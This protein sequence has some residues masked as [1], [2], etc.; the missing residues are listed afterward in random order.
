VGPCLG[1]RSEEDDEEAEDE[2]EDE[3][4]VEEEEEMGRRWKRRRAGGGGGGGGGGGSRGGGDDGFPYTFRVSHTMVR[5]PVRIQRGTNQ[6]TLVGPEVGTEVGAEVGAEVGP[7]VGPEVGLTVGPEVGLTV[8]PEVGL[9]VGPD[10][11]VPVE[12]V[13]VAVGV[14]VEVVGVPV[15]VVGVPVEVVGVPVEVVGVPVGVVVTHRNNELTRAT[16]VVAVSTLRA[17]KAGSHILTRVNAVVSKLILEVAI[18]TCS[19]IMKSAVSREGS[20]SSMKQLAATLQS[21]P[22]VN[23]LGESTDVST[24]LS[25]NLMYSPMALRTGNAIVGKAGCVLIS[26]NA[27]MDVRAGNVTLLSASLL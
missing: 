10:V 24:V 22:T 21:L 16:G 9:A 19:S 26:T 13:G 1:C 2:D 18:P 14:P 11:G 27:P 3:M 23:N 6:D 17:C 25:L 4:V 12:V 20:S 5:S 15:E 7:E 8:G